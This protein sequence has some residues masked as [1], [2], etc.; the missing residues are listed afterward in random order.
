MPE[1]SACRD[2][3]GVED[4]EGTLVASTATNTLRGVQEPAP[5]RIDLPSRLQAIIRS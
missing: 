2:V 3:E 4:E 1:A 5:C